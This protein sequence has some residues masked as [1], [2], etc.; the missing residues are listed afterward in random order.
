MGKYPSN[1]IGHVTLSSL[2]HTDTQI[3]KSPPDRVFTQG[4]GVVQHLAE[5]DDELVGSTEW[6]SYYNARRVHLSLMSLVPK[7]HIGH[8]KCDSG[9]HHCHRPHCRIN[10]PPMLGLVSWVLGTHARVT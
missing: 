9:S 4:M 10:Q 1:E 7:P 8:Q 5:V 6:I 3:L 2:I